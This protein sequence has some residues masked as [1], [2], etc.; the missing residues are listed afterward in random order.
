MI[1][2][3]IDTA[4]DVDNRQAVNSGIESWLSPNSIRESVSYRFPAVELDA[5]K[6]R[7]QVGKRKEVPSYDDETLLCHFESFVGNTYFHADKSSTLTQWTK[8]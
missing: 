5:V 3:I 8:S 1:L 2:N 6:E 7:I 4:K